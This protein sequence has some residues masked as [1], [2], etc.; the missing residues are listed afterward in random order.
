MLGQVDEGGTMDIIAIFFII[1]CSATLISIEIK[2]KKKL[3]QDEKILSKL[4][5]LIE[6]V[7]QSS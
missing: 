3:D 7:K 4:D 2:L 1:I 6:A 5:Q